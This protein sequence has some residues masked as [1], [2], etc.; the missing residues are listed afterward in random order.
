MVAKAVF[1]DSSDAS[2]ESHEL[3]CPWKSPGDDTDDGEEASDLSSVIADAR[4]RV[5]RWRSPEMPCLG[6]RLV[7]ARLTRGR[8]GI[9]CGTVL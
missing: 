7:Y 1:A 6:G 8:V 2:F 3:F 4:R 5:T 9:D